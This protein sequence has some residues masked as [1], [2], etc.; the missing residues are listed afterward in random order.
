MTSVQ[1]CV[2]SGPVDDE[3][4]DNN[5][6]ESSKGPSNAVAFRALETAMEWYEQPSECCP[7][8]LLLMKRIGDLAAE[9]RSDNSPRGS[10]ST[11]PI[12]VY[13]TLGPQMHEQMFRSGGQSETMSPVLSSQV[14]MVFIYR[15]TEGMKG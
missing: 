8:Q 3:G 11:V 15:P 10:R 4:E 6:N 14:S 12:S 5:N 9:K 13:V 2:I 7:T 1:E